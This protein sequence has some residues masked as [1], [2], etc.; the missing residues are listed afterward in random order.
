M[1]QP[2]GSSERFGYEW[3]KYN[4][5]R[6][7]YETQFLKWTPFLQ[8]D[9]WRGKSV[10]DVG[11]GT[12]RNSLWPLKFGAREAVAIDIDEQSLAV[13]RR[14]LSSFPNAKV[15]RQSA[16]EIAFQDH[17]DIAFSIGVIHHLET[18]SLALKQMVKAAK[19]GGNVLIWVYGYENNEWIVRFADPL[20]KAL[21]SRLPIGVVHH[22]SLYP[23]TLLWLLL[24][25]GF[26]RLTYFQLL[27]TFS[28]RHIRSIVF[29]QMLPRIAHYWRRETVQQLMEDA[30]LQNVRL[31]WVNEISWAAIGEK[32]GAGNR[33]EAGSA[34]DR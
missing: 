4:E 5:I 27:R 26:G 12:G 18:P 6:A 20:R 24:R 25:L 8:P 17:F 28:F 32:N 2:V 9:D 21:F 34:T 22:L 33:A 29:D 7:D 19:P 23:T 13:A 31:Q 1:S 16:Y 10:L 14:N 30:G 11:C 3:N 15:F